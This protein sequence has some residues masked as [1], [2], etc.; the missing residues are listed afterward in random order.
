M[1][2][3]PWSPMT[4]PCHSCFLNALLTHINV[5]SPLLVLSQASFEK[6]SSVFA[7][8]ITFEVKGPFC[9]T[10]YKVCMIITGQ[11]LC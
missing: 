11:L 8:K 9:F 3:E 10:D 1:A 7:L 6:L 2:N 4:I 5:Q